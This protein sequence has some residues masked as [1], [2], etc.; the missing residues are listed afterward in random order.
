MCHKLYFLIYPHTEKE[1]G[2]R[3]RE[4]ALPLYAI[5]LLIIIEI[6]VPGYKSQADILCIK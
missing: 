1:R 6:R 5:V 3:G 2:G 4:I